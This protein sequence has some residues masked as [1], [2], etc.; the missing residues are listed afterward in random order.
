MGG[1]Q[2]LRREKALGGELSSG[3][4]GPVRGLTG[5]V[6]R[7]ETDSGEG[8][9]HCCLRSRGGTYLPAAAN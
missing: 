3:E 2:G 6:N 4:D 8:A 9:V 1:R 5:G 7:D